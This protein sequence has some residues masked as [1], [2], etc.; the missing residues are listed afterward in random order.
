MGG[1]F[2]FLLAFFS[3]SSS[4]RFKFPMH[5]PSAFFASN[6]NEKATHMYARYGNMNV[7]VIRSIVIEI[8]RVFFI[9]IFNFQK[10]RER[11]RERER[12]E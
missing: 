9:S 7:V 11:E 3:V 10:K 1:V 8:I 12:F 4:P 6:Q 2:I 5:V